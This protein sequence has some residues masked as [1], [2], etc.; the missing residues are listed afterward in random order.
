MFSESSG[1]VI[2]VFFADFLMV[3]ALIVKNYQMK[4]LKIVSYV[5]LVLWTWFSAFSIQLEPHQDN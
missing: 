3:R 4:L 5:L 1:P 2:V